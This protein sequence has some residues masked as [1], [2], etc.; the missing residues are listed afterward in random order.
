MTWL[1]MAEDVARHWIFT[2]AME[3]DDQGLL[4]MQQI[5]IGTD[6]ERWVLAGVQR[7]D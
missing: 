7:D 2:G 3:I 4:W 6:I 1:D 5:E